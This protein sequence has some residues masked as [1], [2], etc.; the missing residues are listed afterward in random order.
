MV[1]QGIIS[2]DGH[3]RASR[4]T[5]RDYVEQRHLGAFDEWVAEAEAS[6]RPD[7]GNIQPDLGPEAQW[8]LGRRQGDLETQ[9]VVAEVVFPN[10]VPFQASVLDDARPSVDHELNRAGRDAYNRWLADLCAEAS[11]RL[12]GQALIDFDD[13]DRAVDD[14][15]WAKEHGLGGIMMP[16]LYP[17]GTFFFDPKL[18]PVWAAISEVGLPISQHGG[19]GAP[20]Y[21]PGGLAAI[22]TLAHE[23]AFFSGRSLWQMIVGG[24]FDRFPD[25]TM[26]LVETEVHWIGPALRQFDGRVRM[27]DDWTAFAAFL[28]RERAFS[29]LPSEYW[30]T[31]CYAGISPFHEAQLPLDQLGATFEPEPDTFVIRAERAMFGVDYPHFE[32]IYPNTSERVGLLLEVPTMT[33][34]D[35]T[36]LLFDNAADVY[37][38]DRQV[39]A[40][41][42]DR[43]G[44]DVSV[45]P[46]AAAAR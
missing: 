1:K 41:V 2:V 20:T 13:V 34:T 11:G 42:I 7:V 10:G 43:V 14:V 15:H 46:V 39:L 31:N 32:S 6:G 12:A 18:D 8:D 23:H 9:G 30:E 29:R 3:V 40:P 26:V 35:V 21:S 24:V 4:S 45:G 38:F 36:K 22:L 19:T 17:G 28:Q 37:G 25:L 33:E 5:Y 16:G 44:F 27:G